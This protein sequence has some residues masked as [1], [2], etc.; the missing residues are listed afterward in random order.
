MDHGDDTSY[1]S[2]NFNSVQQPLSGC[3]IT[4]N[5]LTNNPSNPE[6]WDYVDF[7]DATG[8]WF[9]IVQYATQFGRWRAHW[10]TGGG[11]SSGADLSPVAGQTIGYT[12]LLT[13]L[14]TDTQFKVSLYEPFSHSFLGE[15]VGSRSSNPMKYV[16]IMNY[17]HHT[18]QAGITN[19]S[20]SLII[21]TNGTYPLLPWNFVDSNPFIRVV[22]P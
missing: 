1:I 12:N 4:V 9:C 16:R 15:A 21:D 13:W 14:I 11:G 6:F 17:L 7:E 19:F 10:G 20:G 8:D 5:N 2:K 22:S 18:N 3:V